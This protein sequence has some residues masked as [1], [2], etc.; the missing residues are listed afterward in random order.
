MD[1][2]ATHQVQSPNLTL[3]HPPG[4]PSTAQASSA[5]ATGSSHA[6]K[7]LPPTVMQ[8]LCALR[9][10]EGAETTKV[11]KPSV[12]M[13]AANAVR[14]GAMMPAIKR[15]ANRAG[16]QAAVNGGGGGS[17]CS[18]AS[19]DPE[20]V[21]RYFA[22][23]L[24]AHHHRLISEHVVADSCSACRGRGLVSVPPKCCDQSV[25]LAQWTESPNGAPPPALCCGPMLGS[26]RLWIAI[27]ALLE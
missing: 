19:D 14:P 21:H 1:F 11:Q 15:A 4:V 23:L 2:P 5:P 16:L 27:V 17:R 9:S 26:A 10:P 20:Y 13:A 3:F 22:A 12:R 8:W 24:A 25:Q 7:C 18:G 6:C